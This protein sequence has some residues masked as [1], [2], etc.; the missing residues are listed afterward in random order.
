MTDKQQPKEQQGADTDNGVWFRTVLRKDVFDKFI[1][2]AK[3]YETGFGKFDYGVAIQIL[4]EH[5][6]QS[7]NSMLTHKVDYITSLLESGV[8]E[9]SKPDTQKTEEED[10]SQYITMLGG[11]KI[12]KG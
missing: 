7:Q 8:E 10:E 12:K 4:L 9:Q 11:T 2:F 3:N 1:A 6:E 5:Y